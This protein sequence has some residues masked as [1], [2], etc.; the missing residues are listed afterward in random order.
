MLK[1]SKNYKFLNIFLLI[2]I[3]LTKSLASY[4]DQIKVEKVIIK[5]E[6][7]LSES[8]ILNY[9]P[10]YP[11]T[12]FNN[13]I[14]N[15][16]TKDLYNS[17]M[18]KKINYKINNDILE[19]FIEEYP[20]INEINFFGNDLLDNET[21]SEIISIKSRD[22]FNEISLNDTIEE[23]KI[24]YQK[25]GRYLAEVLIKKTEISDG[26]VNLNFE[27]SE[28]ALLVVKN[29]NFEGNKS[30]SD[31]ELKSNITTKEDAWYKIFGSNKF[32]PERLEYDKEKLKEFYNRRG[33]IDFNVIVARGD[34]LPNFSGFNLNFIINEGKR[35]TLN[36]VSIETQLIN[37]KKKEFLLNELYLKKGDYFNSKALEESS[38]F[39]INF[40]ES[41]GFNFLKVNP[42]MNKNKDLVDIN[43]IITEGEEKYINKITIIGNTRTN[44]NVIRRELSLLEGDP[45]NKAKLNSSISSIKRLGYFET[46]NYKVLD[47]NVLNKLDIII[48]VK[49]MNTGSVSFG[50]GYS[51]LNDTSMTFGLNERNFLGEG[52]KL[53]LEANLS[54]TKNTYKL[55][56]TE[57]YFMD[58]NLSIFGNIFDQ[59]SEN[60]KGDVKSSSSGVDFGFGFQSNNIS[61]RFKYKFSTSETT[62]SSTSTAASITGEEGVEI[63]TSSLSHSLSQ[64]TRDS[65]FNPTDGYRWRVE[66]TFAGIGGDA[67]FY[68]SVF[69]L[70]SYYPIDYGEYILGFKTGAGFITSFEDKITSSN[71]F[72]L[73]GKTLRGFDNAGVG[74]RDTGNNQAVGGNNFYNLSFEL[75]SDKLMPDDTGLK[76]FVFSDIGS[77]WGTDYETGVQGYDDKEPRITNGFGLS[78]TTPVGP[79]EM[80]WGFPVQS[81]SY[82]V[83]ENFQFSIGTSF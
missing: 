60:T 33:F 20:I 82:D 74:P 69:N 73:G 18:I 72:F 22:I 63:I 12:K 65:F 16:F 24:E 45:F 49:E 51:S 36:E 13:E 44:D 75:K 14:L 38:K 40:F 7:R 61:Q 11:N 81:Q 41:E 77:I 17:G 2:F 32:L 71:R 9:L 59:Q 48:E 30:F 3:L 21:L 35:Y 46:V 76:W 29:I 34:L 64:D 58:R 50:I 15:K 53:R 28:G 25:I 23:I 47:S 8:F 56:M 54:S 83:E 10:N 78:M 31:S 37:K 43:F 68:K 62:T 66:N 52:K 27:I 1:F 55:G 5:G 70:K 57:P 80:V 67:N 42:L 39:L 6:K 4:A 26:R 19:I 79:L